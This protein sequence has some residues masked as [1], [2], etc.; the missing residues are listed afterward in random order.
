MSASASDLRLCNIPCDIA[1]QFALSVMDNG[2]F[3]PRTNHEGP[4]GGQTYSSAISLT[5][6]LDRRGGGSGWST[7]SP[8]RFIAGKE[9]QYPFHKSLCGTT[10][11]VWT[12]AEIVA[13]I[14]IRFPGRPA[15]SELL[16]RLRCRG[17]AT[18]YGLQLWGFT[19]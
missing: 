14:G 3:Q 12:I 16:Y 8:G 6:A 17:I 4:E 18:R 19:Y 9:T 13:F 1:C 7:P 10:G 5:S 15:R 2:E 11:P